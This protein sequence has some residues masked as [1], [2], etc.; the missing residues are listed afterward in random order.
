MGRDLA[1]W[2]PAQMAFWLNSE[3]NWG[4]GGVILAP[5]FSKCFI[6]KQI[7]F[8]YTL[9]K[10]D[11]HCLKKVEEETFFLPLRAMTSQVFLGSK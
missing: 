4:V 3:Y 2:P 6:F 5:F 10:N 1:I 11:E 9:E 7:L 8:H